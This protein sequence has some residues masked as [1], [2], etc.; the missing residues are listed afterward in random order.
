MTLTAD[1]LTHYQEKGAE[2][3]IN[4]RGLQRIVG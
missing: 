3:G 1:D 2:E 4:Y